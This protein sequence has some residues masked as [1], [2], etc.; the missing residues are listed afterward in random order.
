MKILKKQK[1]LEILYIILLICTIN[2]NIRC[3]VP[4]IWSITQNFLSFWAIQ[5]FGQTMGQ[6]LGDQI[7]LSFSLG[8][9]PSSLKIAKVI[10]VFKKRR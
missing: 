8:K 5:N 2:M 7:N 9:F 10:P 3:M 6:P 1:I 4:Q